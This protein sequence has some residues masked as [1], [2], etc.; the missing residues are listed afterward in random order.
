[1]PIFPNETHPTDRPALHT[2]PPFPYTGCYIWTFAETGV[3]VAPRAEGWKPKEAVLLPPIQ[4]VTMRET[5]DD[6][7][8]VA[9]TAVEARRVATG[10]HMGMFRSFYNSILFEL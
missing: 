10:E 8:E 9:D 2:E 5:W 4:R 3:R 7:L 6:D 1:M